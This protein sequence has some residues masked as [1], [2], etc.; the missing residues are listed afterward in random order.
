MLPLFDRPEYPLIDGGAPC[1]IFQ[2]FPALSEATK[3]HSNR[4]RNS[5]VGARLRATRTLTANTSKCK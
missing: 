2:R 4:N 5:E 1:A 3:R